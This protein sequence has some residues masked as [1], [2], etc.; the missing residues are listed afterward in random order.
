M[1]T[2]SIWLIALAA[3]VAVCAQEAGAQ[4]PDEETTGAKRLSF[5]NEKLTFGFT[6]GATLTPDTGSGYAGTGEATVGMVI[7][8]EFADSGAA[9]VLYRRRDSIRPLLGA[10]A[11]TKLT[12]NFSL[13]ANVL[14]RTLGSKTDFIYP[15]Y[16][17]SFPH[18]DATTDL[19][20]IPILFKYRF[21]GSKVRPFL[22]AGPSFRIQNAT[23]PA[24]WLPMSRYGAA[25]AL[26]IDIPFGRRW[27]IT[28]Q[29]NYT[30]WAADARRWGIRNQVQAMIG[31]SF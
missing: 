26:G 18:Q 14:F 13:Q 20:E 17:A 28:P 27:T 5:F 21:G 9:W 24:G 2:K 7:N 6:A 4:P 19:W 22:G 23:P 1:P 29:V 30:R 8:G 10:F 16:D 31:F 15:D 25:V 3:T 12:R 11:E